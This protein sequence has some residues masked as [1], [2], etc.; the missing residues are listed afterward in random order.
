MSKAWPEVTSTYGVPFKEIGPYS[1]EKGVQCSFAQHQG[2]GEGGS[3]RE[4]APGDDTQCSVK[5]PEIF[6]N[7]INP[8]HRGTAA[9][10]LFYPIPNTFQAQPLPSHTFFSLPV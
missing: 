7:F 1:E 9:A 10:R 3:C 8:S 6:L 2:M 4:G 5:V